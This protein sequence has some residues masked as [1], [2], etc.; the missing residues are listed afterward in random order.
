MHRFG[1]TVLIWA[2]LGAVLL[3]CTTPPPRRD[4]GAPGTEPAQGASQPKKIS[5]AM[6]GNPAS[7]YV[8]VVTGSGGNIRGHD[9]FEQLV[10]VGMT[11]PDDRGAL[12]PFL[13]EAVPSIE[14]GLWRVL[15]DG[16]METTWKIREGARWHDGTPITVDDFLFTIRV[17]QDR[18]LVFP[19]NPAYDLVRNI[20]A[21]DQRTVTVLWNRP[22]IEADDLFTMPP[23]PKHLLER[24]YL[25]E[26]A[27]FTNLP[28]WSDEFVG[29]GPYRLAEWVR[30]SHAVLR[31]NDTYVLGRPKIEEIVVRFIPDENAFI[32]NILANNVDVTLAKSLTLEQT[33]EIREQWRDGRV[34]VTLE[35]AMKIWPQFLNPNPTVVGDVRFRRAML[36]GINR[37][38]MVDSFMSGLSQ[39]AHSVLLPWEAEF[40]EVQST[41]VKYDYDTRRAVQLIES[42]GLTRGSDGFFRD[43][44]GQRI[45]V[46]ISAT[47]DDQNTKPMFAVADDWQ[48]IGVGVEPVVIAPQRARD[49]EYRATFPAFTL[50]GGASGVTRLKELHSS[51]ARVPEN[52]YTGGN[53]SRYMNAEFDAALERFT[54][55]IPRRERV[56]ALRE[57]VRHMTDQ[58]NMMNLFYA[59]ATTMMH[60]RMRNAGRAPSWNAQEWDVAS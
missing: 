26:K 48:R 2:V 5:T 18:E 17:F 50:Q 6:M 31:A 56:D 49:R 14:N 15:S 43:A 52:N 33:L 9:G 27:R 42:I 40:D 21:P 47:A 51:Q 23:L 8:G 39:I 37:Q 34:E 16:G 20:E 28:Y 54:S 53:Y 22:F 58:L 19:R 13:A 55:T 36:H 7:P 44:A 25:E 60:N 12:R 3:G 30:D 57:V 45:S 10:A 29:T 11:M 35:T 24:P 4:P 38:Q 32:A 59:A 41:V 46:E 1:H